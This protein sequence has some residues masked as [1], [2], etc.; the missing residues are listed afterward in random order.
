ME[1]NLLRFF[2]GHCLVFRACDDTT[3]TM[4]TDQKGLNKIWSRISP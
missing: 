2:D 3:H 4:D 1:L